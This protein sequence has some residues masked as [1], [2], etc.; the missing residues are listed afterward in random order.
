MKWDLSFWRF[1]IIFSIAKTGLWEKNNDAFLFHVG[2]FSNENN[3][4][5]RVIVFPFSLMAG[6]IRKE[7]K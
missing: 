3:T 5:L 7:Q 6:F 2:T 1:V 4:A